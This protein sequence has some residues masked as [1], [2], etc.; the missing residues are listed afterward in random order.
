MLLIIN[1][2]IILRMEFILFTIADITVAVYQS[3]RTNRV[4]PVPAQDQLSDDASRQEIQSCRLTQPEIS[5][6]QDN[7]SVQDRLRPGTLI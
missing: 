6:V 4:F 3:T 1:I 5:S 7:S 2:S